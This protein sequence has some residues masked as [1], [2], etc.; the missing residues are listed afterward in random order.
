MAMKEVTGLDVHQFIFTDLPNDGSYQADKNLYPY[1][2]KDGKY[3]ENDGTSFTYGTAALLMPIT[4]GYQVQNDP[5][6]GL[7]LFE[8]HDDDNEN[9]EYLKS[10]TQVNY[11]SRIDNSIYSVK[12]NAQNGSGGYKINYNGDQKH[13]WAYANS[14]NQNNQKDLYNFDAAKSYGF[15]YG[16]YTNLKKF[17]TSE[18][19]AILP[20]WTNEATGYTINV[21]IKGNKLTAISNN[22]TRTMYLPYGSKVLLFLREGGTAQLTK[23]LPVVKVKWDEGMNF[24]SDNDTT[25]GSLIDAY[26]INRKQGPL[27]PQVVLMQHWNGGASAIITNLSTRGMK[28]ATDLK[29]PPEAFAKMEISGIKLYTTQ[30]EIN[31]D[32]NISFV[33]NDNLATLMDN[34]SWCPVLYTD[35]NVISEKFN[36][37]SN[38]WL[39]AKDQEIIDRPNHACSW[40]LNQNRAPYQIQNYF[41]IKYDSLPVIKCFNDEELIP[42][43]SATCDMDSHFINLTT[44]SEMFTQFDMRIN[45]KRAGIL[46]KTNNLV[47]IETNS[48]PTN[49]TVNGNQYNAQ[50]TGDPYI[51]TCGFSANLIVKSD[52][53]YASWITIAPPEW[54]GSIQGDLLNIDPSTVRFD[55]LNIKQDGTWYIVTATIMNTNNFDIYATIAYGINNQ[56]QKSNWYLKAGTNTQKIELLR[57]PFSTELTSVLNSTFK[58]IGY[59]TLVKRNVTA[60]DFI[61]HTPYQGPLNG[62]YMKITNNTGE[63]CTAKIS[64]TFNGTSNRKNISLAVG[65]TEV[66]L[67]ALVEGSNIIVLKNIVYIING[68]SIPVTYNRTYRFTVSGP[69]TDPDM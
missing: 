25:V 23:K 17:G 11:K 20:F 30:I 33:L 13:I 58:A 63:S 39:D 49:I 5:W 10:E 67:G 61:V 27:T 59:N 69:V 21:Q 68:T 31:K 26:I 15:V 34:L 35:D 14:A 45:V 32:T 65:D 40:V 60:H 51:N 38:L 53:N 52:K 36:V 2:K 64:Y 48:D 43:S 28:F 3:Y 6:S 57:N 4:Y 56:T 54:N 12:L 19:N 18:P 55:S 16:R 29:K 46:N 1:V 7:A 47:L 50:I 37:T 41:T 62:Y 22:E 8:H 24:N 66:R 9:E 44:P 42:S